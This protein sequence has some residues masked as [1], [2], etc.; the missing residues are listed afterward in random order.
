M[1]GSSFE[2]AYFSVPCAVERGRSLTKRTLN[3]EKVDDA[4]CS[5]ALQKKQQRFVL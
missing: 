2:K 4:V 1:Q 5:F 3:W